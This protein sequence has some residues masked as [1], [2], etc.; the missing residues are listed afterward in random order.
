MRQNAALTKWINATSGS[1]SVR[2]VD[3][4]LQQRAA[5]LLLWAPR[6]GD[7]DRLLHGASAADAA[8]SRSM[9]AAARRAR[10]NTPVSSKCEQCRLVS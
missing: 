1:L 3:R 2:P 7:I 6:A 5:G 8:A 4:P 10:R 9:S